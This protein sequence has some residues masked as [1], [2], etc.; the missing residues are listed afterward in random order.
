MPL[1][2]VL[3]IAALGAWNLSLMSSA[4]AANQ[5]AGQLREAIVAS[6]S[7]D[8]TVARL[9]GS[10]PA[11]GATGFAAFPADGPGS[12][13]IRG[14]EPAPA[15]RTYQAWYLEGGEPRSAGLVQVGE[16]GI[17]LLTGLQPGG[18]LD[19]VALTLEPA[20]GVQA[21]TSDPIVAGELAQEG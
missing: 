2:A 6:T 21:P 13:V 16:D 20:G 7:A 8:A 14:L 12:I 3:V 19:Q 15:G 17:A 11:A 5:R 1:A 10:G 4:N 18:P 9:Q